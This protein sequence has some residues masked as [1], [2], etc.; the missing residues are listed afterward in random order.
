M[1]LRGFVEKDE[2][3][4]II[5]D[6]LKSLGI[7][8]DSYPLDAFKI[9]SMYKDRLEINFQPFPSLNL[10][11]LLYKDPDDKFSIM[12][13]NSLKSKK[14]QNFDI[15]HE[16]HHYWFHPAGEH[17]CYDKNFIYQ[18]KGIEWQ[19]NAGTAHALMPEIGFKKKYIYFEGNINKLSDHFFA[20]PTAVK[21]RIENLNL[22]SVS[23]MR[24]MLYKSK[25]VHHCS[26]CGNSE[27]TYRDNYC[28]ICGI[29]GFISRTGY[30]WSIYSKG[31][32]IENRCPSCYLLLDSN[33]RYCKRCGTTSTSN[34]FSLPGMLN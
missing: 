31:H 2:F 1:A 22:P 17:L 27:I 30:K 6:K 15:M 18:H 21:Y 9:A 26:V 34:V 13:I 8:E 20:T 16:L 10:G 32:T 5:D 33:A 23:R 7:T 12:A 24:G 19:A 14:A 3:Y 29:E 28:K 25:K 11:G 4:K